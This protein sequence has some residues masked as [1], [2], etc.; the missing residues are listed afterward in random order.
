M[1]DLTQARLRELLSYDPDTGVFTRLRN[2]RIA[3]TLTYQGY[4][5]IAIDGKLYLGHRL[6]WLYMTGS[7][8]SLQIDHKD[9]NEANNVFT[10]LRLATP[11]Q[12]QWNTGTQINNKCGLKGVSRLI[13]GRWMA[14]ITNHYKTKY[15]GTYSTPEEAHAAYRRA[16]AEMNGEFANF[17]G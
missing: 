12:N 11:T 15:L 17:G 3:G 5:Q 9:R 6:A 16:A 8:P 7:F 13:N 10:N 14:R 1:S 2:G 4:V